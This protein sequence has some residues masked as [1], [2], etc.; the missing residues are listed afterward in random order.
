MDRCYGGR[1]N[2]RALVKSSIYATD[3][4]YLYATLQVHFL[5]RVSILNHNV[6]RTESRANFEQML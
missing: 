2:R 6:S 5:K 1:E 4:M 3:L